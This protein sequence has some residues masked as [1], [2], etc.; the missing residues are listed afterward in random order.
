MKW[1]PQS[2]EIDVARLTRIRGLA[3]RQRS[4]LVL[5][6]RDKLP[7]QVAGEMLQAQV[8]TSAEEDVLSALMNLGYQRPTAE[9]ALHSIERNG[10][11]F[12]ENVSRGFERFV[13]IGS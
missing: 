4:E 12:E 2:A 9:K 5:E 13:E 3:R 7:A 10:G 1:L 11:C 6:L 8:L